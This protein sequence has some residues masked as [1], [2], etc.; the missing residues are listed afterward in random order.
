ML[1]QAGILGGLLG[2]LLL[3]ASCTPSFPPEIEATPD[4]ATPSPKPTIAPPV[5]VDDPCRQDQGISRTSAGEVSFSAGSGEWNGYN[6]VVS[7]AADPYDRLVAAQLFSGFVYRGSDG[8]ICEN[9]EYGRMA[10]T[11]EDPLTVTYTID[12]KAV[13]S[14]GTPVTVNDYLLDWATRNPAFLAKWAAKQPDA[15]EPFRVFE[16]EPDASSVS[17]P[18]GPQGAVG[19]KQFTLTFEG[20]ISDWK[21]FL[22]APL[23]A[24]VAATEAGLE[25]DRLAQAILD[26]D[27]A[28][29]ARVAEFW[30]TGWA[31]PSGE[32]PDEP[33]QVL[34]SSGPYRL[35]SGGWTKGEALTL[36]ANP[37]YWGTPAATENLL[38]RF[39][40]DDALTDAL[41]SGEVDVIAPPATAD[42]VPQLEAIGA[43]VNVLQYSTTVS[44]QLSFNVQDGTVFGGAAHGAALREAFAR[45]VPREQIVDMLVGLVKAD[46]EAMNSYQVLP[47]QDG[48]ADVVAASYDGRFDEVDVV[49]ARK[50]IADSGVATPIEVRVGGASGD[51]EDARVIDIIAASC[52][53]A[54]FDVIDASSPT[55][56]EQELVDGEYDVALL[57]TDGLDDT[58]SRMSAYLTDGARNHTGYS[59]PKVDEAATELI[60]ELDPAD[61]QELVAT[62]ETELWNDLYG[63]PLFARPG[64]SAYDATVKNVRASATPDL[65]TWNASQWVR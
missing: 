38:L 32:L 10:V 21:S 41:A 43:S 49:E 27:A 54:G 5:E 20:S 14:D 36:E 60:A 48:Y 26:R 31:F 62:I 55:F 44:D 1:R 47:F 52:E 51:T 11:S 42:V 9:T 59:N 22:G 33:E 53:K 12:D 46:A 64:V 15:A 7:G 35:Q 29:V 34:P 16:R 8:S 13:W 17:A 50:L 4:V 6:A 19:D 30:N 56:L 37:S 40:D 63:L 23:P 57:S 2:A 18:D 45:C 28:T 65:T 58:A 39:I 3:S 25:P 24:H 61:R